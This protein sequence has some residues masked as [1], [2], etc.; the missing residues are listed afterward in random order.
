MANSFLLSIKLLYLFIIIKYL[1]I[2]NILKCG[3]KINLLDDIGTIEY[4]NCTIIETKFDNTND[5]DNYGNGYGNIFEI[6]H[7]LN[8]DNDIDND[9]DDDSYNDYNKDIIKLQILELNIIN[10]IYH[11]I[12]LL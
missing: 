11:Q 12:L 5:E 2:K 10:L 1:G 4:I 3:G 9:E 6:I 8:D 7:S